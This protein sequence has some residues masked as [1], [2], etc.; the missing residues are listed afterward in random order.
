MGE[1]RLIS[2]PPHSSE[3]EV[4]E[5]DSFN[6]PPRSCVSCGRT[7]A[8]DVNVCPYCGHDYRPQMMGPQPMY[9]QP[10][11]QQ[12][13]FQGSILILIILILLCW[14]AALIYLLIKW[15]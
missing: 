5:M 9:G 2:L 10:M 15:V 12:K 6:R 1:E 13:G 11:P 7:I 8:W 3:T 4:M 14:P